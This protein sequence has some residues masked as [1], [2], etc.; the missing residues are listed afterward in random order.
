MYYN[1]P[2]NED[3]KHHM[4][5]WTNKTYFINFISL[6]I[7]HLKIHLWI[8]DIF[9]YVT[10]LFGAIYT[11]PGAHKFLCGGRVCFCVHLLAYGLAAA[12]KLMSSFPEY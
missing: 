1:F 9:I 11:R 10:D 6:N 7:S 4:R 3:N 2:V 12:P 5:Q 8:K